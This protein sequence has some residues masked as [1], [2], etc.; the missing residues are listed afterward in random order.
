MGSRLAL[1]A[2][3]KRRSNGERLASRY[4][5]DLVPHLPATH[6]PGNI[7]RSSSHYAGAWH[8]PHTLQLH[9]QSENVR[10]DQPLVG[11]QIPAQVP[12]YRDSNAKS[13]L[14]KPCMCLGCDGCTAPA[15]HHTHWEP[16]GYP[17]IRVR[18]LRALRIDADITASVSRFSSC[19]YTC[20][21]GAHARRKRI[22]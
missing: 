18:I 4:T 14:G 13:M 17:P 7:R 6:Q 8:V 15:R 22:G 10:P 5:N 16:G 9:S 19:I 2:K 3:K 12:R 11:R 20:Y 1:A 21:R